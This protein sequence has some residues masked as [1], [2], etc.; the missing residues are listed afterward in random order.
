MVIINQMFHTLIHYI[1]EVL[2]SLAI[3]FFLSGLIHEFIP[4]KIIE[5][6]LGGKGIWPLLYATIAGTILPICCVGSLPVALSLHKKGAR[7][8]SVVSFLIATP[9]TSLTALF[10]TY[11]LFGWGFTVYIF[12]AVIIMGV[13]IGAIANGVG[14]RLRDIEEPA[15]CCSSSECDDSN[16][17]IDPVCGMAVSED[18]DLVI[19]FEG[20]KIYFC[21]AHCLDKFK[22]NPEKYSSGNVEGGS[23]CCALPQTN[24]ETFGQKLWSALKFAFW[25]MP[26]DIG[27]ELLIGLI[28]AVIIASLDP[29][30]RI[31]NTYLGGFWGYPFS[32]IVGILIYVCST[33]SVPLAHALYSQGMNIGAVMLFLIVGPITSWST[34]LVVRKYFGGKML[35]FYLI[36]ISIFSLIAG[37]IFSL[38]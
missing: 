19:R 16:G 8:G 37:Y 11:S 22:Q 35:A 17:N 26:R 20:R 24:P 4:T 36:S 10:V 14:F 25:T 21:S 3:G 2:P 32:L 23:S 31:I 6:H 7:I 29:I 12:F 27:L 18:T 9:A 15:S 34:I 38:I 28:L 5:R 30:G 33:A 13:L 1:A